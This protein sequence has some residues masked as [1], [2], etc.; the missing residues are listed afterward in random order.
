[1]NEYEYFKLF[2]LGE[3]YSHPSI[4]FDR[5]SNAGVVGLMLSARLHQRFALPNLRRYYST[6]IPNA[7][8]F[9][10]ST[11]GRAPFTDVNFNP[12]RKIS[13]I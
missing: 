3:M 10:T 1:M 9:K 2:G 4:L 5:S 6:S 13:G 11:R 12:V 7:L 8:R